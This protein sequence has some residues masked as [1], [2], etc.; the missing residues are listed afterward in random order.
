[1]HARP[2]DSPLLVQMKHGSYRQMLRA[3]AE[4]HDGHVV[5]KELVQAAL[6]SGRFDSR[7]KA[8]KTMWST[9]TQAAKKGEFERVDEGVYEARPVPWTD[10]QRANREAEGEVMLQALK[11][12]V[13][14]SSPAMYTEPNMPPERRVG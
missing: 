4:D 6:D 1:M 11:L 9:I 12:Q 2:P 3:W 14:A 10:E 5:V 7:Q 13:D 8:H